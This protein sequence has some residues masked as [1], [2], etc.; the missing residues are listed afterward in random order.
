MI[1]INTTYNFLSKYMYKFSCNIH[2]P[3][4]EYCTKRLPVQQNQ[5]VAKDKLGTRC[6]YTI[7]HEFMDLAILQNLLTTSA[8]EQ[9]RVCNCCRSLLDPRESLVERG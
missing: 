9:L 8:I 7:G 6:H 5:L 2:A 3:L 4:R 1:L